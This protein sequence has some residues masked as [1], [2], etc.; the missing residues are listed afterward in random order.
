[1]GGSRGSSQAPCLFRLLINNFI[2]ILIVHYW[3]SFKSCLNFEFLFGYQLSE[4]LFDCTRRST[5]RPMVDHRVYQPRIDK[6]GEHFPLDRVQWASKAN[7]LPVLEFFSIF[8]NSSSSF[9]VPF[10]FRI[11]KSNSV[12]SVCA[13]PPICVLQFLSRLI[14]DRLI[15]TGLCNE[16]T[17][18][19]F[20]ETCY[21]LFRD[22]PV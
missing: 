16:R 17:L 7:Q 11:L 19:S 6:P 12:R 20:R 2:S 5:P 21:L 14:D 15:L 1:M 10:Y 8:L 18:R 13:S 9:L 3:K 4:N 22:I